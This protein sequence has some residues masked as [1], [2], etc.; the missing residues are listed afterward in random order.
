MCA[1]NEEKVQGLNNE[2]T[3]RRQRVQNL[4][5]KVDDAS[6]YSRL[7]HIV[8]S[9]RIMKVCQCTKRMKIRKNSS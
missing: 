5:N 9:Q 1:E 3:A 2:I 6:Q 4:E 8:V 7:D